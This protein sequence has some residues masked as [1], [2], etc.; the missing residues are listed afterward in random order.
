M[1]ESEIAALIDKKLEH[2][3]TQQTEFSRI[4]GRLTT[5]LVGDEQIQHVGVIQRMKDQKSIQDAHQKFIDDWNLK[6]AELKGAIRVIVGVGM[7]LGIVGQII[8]QFVIA[9]LAG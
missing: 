9:K 5:I 3:V 2:I 7:V 8:V 1:T 4:V 6:S